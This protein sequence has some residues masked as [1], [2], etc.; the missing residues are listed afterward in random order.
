[1]LV[2]EPSKALFDK[3]ITLTKNLKID[4][5]WADQN[6]VSE[7]YPNWPNEKEKQLPIYYNCFGRHI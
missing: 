6:I 4:R 3:I 5:P 1:M 2:I 7:L